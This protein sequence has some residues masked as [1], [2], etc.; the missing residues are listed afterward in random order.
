MKKIKYLLVAFLSTTLVTGCRSNADY[1]KLALAGSK[2]LDAVDLLLAESTN[3]RINLTSEQILANDRIGTG[4][5]ATQYQQSSA[6][7]L[8]RITSIDRIAK[9][10]L[11]LKKYFSLLLELA[12]SDAPQKAQ[13]EV[14]KVAKNITQLGAAIRTGS[15]ANTAPPNRLLGSGVNFIVKLQV[16]QA[17]KKELEQRGNLITNELTIQAEA[18]ER[19]SEILLKDKERLIQFQENR[20]VI[21]P[22]IQDTRISNE[23][24]WIKTRERI[25]TMNITSEKFQSASSALNNFKNIFQSVLEGKS[26]L[27]SI[28]NFL[29]E[30]ETF[31]NLVANNK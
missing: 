31:T 16:R 20:F 4:I 15:G 3:T 18:L 10:N 19:I 24:E 11:L 22:I 13:V 30:V 1:S 26:D 21:G 6:A 14:E 17:L 25:M 28:D 27:S 7:D 8:K 23:D 5:D 29:T 2:Y 9:H 12:N